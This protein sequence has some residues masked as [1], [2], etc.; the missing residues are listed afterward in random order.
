MILLNTTDDKV[1][2][3][4]SIKTSLIDL[5]YGPLEN[6]CLYILKHSSHD[7]TSMVYE[8]ATTLRGIARHKY[9]VNVVNA[10]LFRDSLE[11]KDYVNKR[12]GVIIFD[13]AECLEHIE[14]AVETLRGL[15]SAYAKLVYVKSQKG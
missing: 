8:A 4:V 9:P 13:E 6:Q 3:R 11:I 7:V 14:G 10:S 5:I 15:E 1:F 2:N 12:G